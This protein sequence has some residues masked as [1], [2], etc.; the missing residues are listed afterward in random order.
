MPVTGLTGSEKLLSIDFRP[1]TGQLYGITDA[2]RLYVINQDSG[3]ARPVGS[4]LNTTLS[5][6]IVSID[7]NPTVDRLRVVTN[8]GQNLRLNPENGAVAGVDTAVVGGTIVGV[9][10]NNNRAGVTTTTLFD[11]DSAADRLFQQNPPNDGKLVPVG[12]VFGI[13]HSGASGFDVSPSGVALASLLVNGVSQL[14]LINLSTGI[15][16]QYLGNLPQ[17]LSALAIP[18]DPVAYS[19]AVSNNSLV[20]FNPMNVTLAPIS[21]ALTGLAS[22]ESV[23]GLDFRPLNG[24][25]YALGNSNRI[26]TI[27]TASGQ[28]TVVG[29]GTAF[30]TPLSGTSFGFD[31]NPTVDRIRLVSNTGQNLRFNPITGGSAGQDTTLQPNTSVVTA[32]AYTNNFANAT[33]TVLF[34]LDTANN[35]LQIQ[36]PPNDGVLTNVGSLGVAADSENGFDIGGRSANAYALLTV[37]GS[38]GLYQINLGTGGATSLGSFPLAGR[39]LAIGLGFWRTTLSSW[40]PLTFR[41]FIARMNYENLLF[42]TL[43][44]KY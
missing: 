38:T 36:N 31:F 19:I 35:R 23:V 33:T 7:F 18:T 43:I 5:G 11:I 28:A 29:N 16:Q 12:G 26:Y 41:I 20:I 9:A 13:D 4:V 37:A 25:L 1:A 14:Y 39:A 8:T 21:K 17:T 44:F 27:N 3:V 34:V 32:A 40:S 15:L 42:Q 10:Y 22:G 6:S 30:S 24:Q 2:S